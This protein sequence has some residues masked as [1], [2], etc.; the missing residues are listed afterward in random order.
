MPKPLMSE[1]SIHA[2]LIVHREEVENRLREHVKKAIRIKSR[3]IRYPEDLMASRE[4]KLQWTQELTEMLLRFFDS[5]AVAEECN[6]WV[7]PLLNEHD[8]L[9]KFIDAFEA[10]MNHRIGRLQL[11]LQRLNS[12]ATD[13]VAV[14]SGQMTLVDTPAASA[15]A[16]MPVPAAAAPV[17]MPAAAVAAPRTVTAGQKPTAARATARSPRATVI[18]HGIA[19]PC[20]EAVVMFL[21][22]LGLSPLALDVGASASGAGKNVPDQLAEQSEI[23]FAL[24]LVSA[25]EISH[26]RSAGA[27]VPRTSMNLAF[28]LGCCAGRV[29]SRRVVVL[30]AG[31]SEFFM[32]EMGIAYLPI[33]P[34]DGWQLRLA[35][36]M[37]RGGFEVDLNRLC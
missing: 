19:S 34:N 13:V 27:E 8:E 6:T 33:D 15:P 16:T 9:S 7:G 35:R 14:P 30:Y 4:Q 25:D 3:R 12:F 10:E 20:K 28:E 36:Q 22:K 32:D 21:E 11:V 23:G 29:S 2:K 17:A 37:R 18:A 24:I 1:S 26:L 31:G 5:D